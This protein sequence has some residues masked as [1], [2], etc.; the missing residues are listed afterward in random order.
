MLVL[1]ANIAG[2]LSS[3]FDNGKAASWRIRGA[4]VS[5]V[6]MVD[7]RVYHISY[8]LLPGIFWI[9]LRLFS[10]PYNTEA[11]CMRTGVD[12]GV[13]CALTSAS[14]LVTGCCRF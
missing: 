2:S 13:G 4:T 1:C 12:F 6:L 11:N 8:L 9:W 5:K 7:S 3:D 10:K 14:S